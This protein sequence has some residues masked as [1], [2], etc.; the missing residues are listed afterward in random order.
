MSAARR[1][2]YSSSPR[3]YSHSSTRD[4]HSHSRCCSTAEGH[5][6]RIVYLSSAKLRKFGQ[7]LKSETYRPAKGGKER[8]SSLPLVGSPS[9]AFSQNA[10]CALRYFVLEHALAPEGQPHAVVR[11]RDRPG[12]IRTRVRE[13]AIRIRVV[14]RPQR[15]TASPR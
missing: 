4:R 14:A 11:I 7:M 3:R 15:D 2:S 12:V 8:G 10:L 6:I 1:S 13:T 5:G 9:N